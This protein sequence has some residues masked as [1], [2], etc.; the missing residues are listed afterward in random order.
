MNKFQLVGILVLM[1]GLLCTDPYV[2]A[3][4]YN[5]KS[6]TSTCSAAN[7]QSCPPC[8]NGNIQSAYNFSNATITTRETKGG[9]TAT[10][11]SVLCWHSGNCIWKAVADK[12]CSHNF[13]VGTDACNSHLGETCY[14]LDGIGAAVPANITSY[15]DVVSSGE[16]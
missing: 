8:D 7:N 9:D 4:G 5:Y 13:Y 12:R 2:V 10:A 16:G 15:S 1:S 14:E 11:N 6:N 3:G